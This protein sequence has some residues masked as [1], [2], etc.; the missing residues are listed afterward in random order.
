MPKKLFPSENLDDAASAINHYSSLYICQRKWRIFVLI[1]VWYSLI[2]NQ[3]NL[4]QNSNIYKPEEYIF[5]RCCAESKLMM[6]S[7]SCI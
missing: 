1:G 6:I 3:L 4:S 5:V 2:T 7:I